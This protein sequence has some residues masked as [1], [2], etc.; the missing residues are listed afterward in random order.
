[1]G[2]TT[3]DR[4]LNSLCNVMGWRGTL[5]SLNAAN[6]RINREIERRDR[7]LERTLGRLDKSVDKTLAQVAR[8][9][10]RLR[11]NPIK[12]LDIRYSRS[13][14]IPS[15]T[16]EFDTSEFAITLSVGPHFRSSKAID[17]VDAEG[18]S[19]G[20]FR[21]K[22]LAVYL[23]WYATLI[24]FEISHAE[25][26]FRPKLNWVKRADRSTSPVY[27]LDEQNSEYY[28]P[29]A[30]DSG[31]E[32]LPKHPKTILLAF[33]PFRVETTTL[34]I[35][36]SDLKT[37]SKRGQKNSFVFRLTDAKIRRQISNQLSS[38]SLLESAEKEIQE[39]KEAAAS[40]IH[41]EHSSTGCAIVLA[42]LFSMPALL[43]AFI[44]FLV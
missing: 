1:M 36:V 21:V 27:L 31:G 3:I 38:Q 8:L 39:K 33:E 9:E 40:R 4:S 20:S 42:L 15:K 30:S 28:Y 11:T 26:D 35:R 5:R 18:H 41:E 10:D 6:K 7:S 16:F 22:P 43:S 13:T 2:E 25:P 24:P 32:V 34:Q 14:G 17:E 29:I 23:A 44:L 12:T 19:I 37:G